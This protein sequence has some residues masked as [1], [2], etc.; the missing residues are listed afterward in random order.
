M[1]K[2]QWYEGRDNRT[3]RYASRRLD[4]RRWIAITASPDSLRRYDGQVGILTA[5]NLL[6]R[7]TP[8][9]ALCFPD[10]PIHAALHWAGQSLH[11]VVLAQMRAADPH[12]QF[13]ARNIEAAD[14]VF[15]TGRDGAP[16]V[17]QGTGWDAYTGPGP[18]PLPDA[19]DTNPF[20]AAF[21]AILAASQIFVH[22][23]EVPDAP[24]TCNA[25]NW[26]NELA[27]AAPVFT[28]R[29]AL[30]DIWVVGAGSVGTAA[31]YFLTLATRNFSTTIIDHDVVK[32]HNLDRS[33][34]FVETDIRRL[35]VDATRDYLTSVGLREVHVDPHALHE[36]AL[37]H[38]RQAGTP[39][40]IIA[41]ANEKK[42]RYYIEAG[43]PPLQL[44]ATTGQNWQVALLRHEPFGEACSLCL[45][46]ADETPASTACATAPAKPGPATEDEQVDAALP[47]LS[48]AAGLMTACETVKSRL[49]GFPFSSNRVV[50]YTRPTPLLTSARLHHR[51]GCFC[52]TR[53]A[54]IY[55]AM[56]RKT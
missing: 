47:F 18:S 34:V 11:N 54:G 42:I 13:T 17:V 49:P 50:L 9:I 45:F 46:P 35:K 23:F 2:R 55:R 33:P 14:H 7:M 8:S 40:V 25:F 41:A 26:E 43:F 52:E 51:A 5:T 38:S 48:F 1:D 28:P 10:V 21:A 6:G 31:L 12:G 37:W 56:L 24:F 4:H 39:D 32:L 36:S 30:G 29:A 16:S 20:G 15:H 3:L 22:E 27:A 44:Y 53:D 19:D